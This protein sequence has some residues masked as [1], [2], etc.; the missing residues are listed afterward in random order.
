MEE[1]GE[2][3]K[4]F[5]LAVLDNET[6]PISTWGRAST[7]DY[8][9]RGESE[10]KREKEQKRKKE[11]EAELTFLSLFPQVTRSRTQQFQLYLQSID[12]DSD[13]DCGY[14]RHTF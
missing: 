4:G 11:I 5:L 8:T 12:P 14:E 2:V 9:L 10:E 1:V 6:T 7:S 13:S 3:G